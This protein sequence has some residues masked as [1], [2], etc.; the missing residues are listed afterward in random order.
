M[1]QKLPV[2]A[3]TAAVRRRRVGISAV[4]ISSLSAEGYAQLGGKKFL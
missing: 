4:M 2:T 1:K 3:M